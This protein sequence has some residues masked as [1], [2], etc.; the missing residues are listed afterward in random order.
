MNLCGRLYLCTVLLHYVRS[1][2][3]EQVI[4]FMWPYFSDLVTWVWVSNLHADLV[5]LQRSSQG[6]I[7]NYFESNLKKIQTK[8]F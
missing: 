2:S 1:G 4:M 8:Y 7:F 5:H 3:D 6:K